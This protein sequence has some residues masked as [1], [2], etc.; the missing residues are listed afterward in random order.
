MELHQLRSFCVV[1]EE[2]HITR[3]ARRLRITQPALTRQ[4][5]ALEKS[6]HVALIRRVGRT[7]ELTDAGVTFY[8]DSL[9][10]LEKLRTS[11]VMTREAAR[12]RVGHI[13][14]GLCGCAAFFPEVVASLKQFR[15]DWPL[16]GI[17]FVQKRTTELIIALEKHRIDVAYIR[18]LAY[19][20]NGMKRGILFSE[21]VLVALP[22][23]HKLSLQPT[24]TLAYMR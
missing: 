2:L 16:V 22:E 11:I 10:I 12:G 24:V 13:T 21:E 19:G 14:V 5:K 6:L 15:L 18:P 20:M 3:A 1:A 17:T 9:P 7:I 4:I 23:T 8:Q